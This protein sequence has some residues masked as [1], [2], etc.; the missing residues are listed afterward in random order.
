ML[1][2]ELIFLHSASGDGCNDRP[3]FV[4]D[5]RGFLSPSLHRQ[6]RHLRPRRVPAQIET[7]VAQPKMS[8]IPYLIGRQSEQNCELLYNYIILLHL[9][10]MLE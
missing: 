6:H 10:T 4:G 3:A 2:R 8:E 1:R 5:P 7:R 9:N